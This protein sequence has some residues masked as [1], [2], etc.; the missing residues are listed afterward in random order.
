MS[1]AILASKNRIAPCQSMVW[2]ATA[3]TTPA[4]MLMYGKEAGNR[5]QEIDRQHYTI[6]NQRKQRPQCRL[7]RNPSPLHTYNSCYLDNS[8]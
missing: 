2:R 8:K 3:R 1:A 5:K 6:P 4:P 7:L